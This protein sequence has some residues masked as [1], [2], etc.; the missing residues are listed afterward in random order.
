[1][2][3]YSALFLHT[4]EQ[5]V[6]FT[7]LN[8]V[9]KIQLISH[10][11]TTLLER[12]AATEAE[13]ASTLAARNSDTK[14]SA[15]DKHEV[16]RAM[17]QQELDQLELQLA[18]TRALLH[19]LDRIPVE[20]TFDQVAFGS[21]VTTDQGSYFIAIG[22][23]AVEVNNA[24]CYAISLASPIGQVLRGKMDGDEINFNGKTLRIL[25]IQ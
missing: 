20:R 3:C 9:Q 22:M 2:K 24:T 16:G 13:F 25:S 19:E 6:H 1:M 17:V 12:I 23:G 4:Q 10:L 8:N 15:G 14:S 21:L 5:T 11:R 18:K 7:L